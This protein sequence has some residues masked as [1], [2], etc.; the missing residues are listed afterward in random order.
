MEKVSS[1]TFFTVL[2]KGVCQALGWFFG[3]FGYKRDGKF[4]KCVWGLFATSAAVVMGIIAIIT[5]YEVSDGLWDMYKTQVKDKCCGSSYGFVSSYISGDIYYHDHRDGHGYI[6]NN[7]TGKKLIKDVAWISEPREKDTLVCFSDGK[8]RG[9]FGMK[10]GRVVVEPKYDHAWVFSEGL[11]GV[12]DGGIIKFIDAAGKVVI[13]NKMV[14]NPDM[15]GYVFHGG[16]CVIDSDDDEKHGLMDR[17]GKMALPLEYDII[18]PANDYELWRVQK[19]G[20]MAVFDKEMK[21]VVPFLECSSIYIDE[22]TIDVTM[23]DHTIRKYDMDGTLINDFYISCIRMLE[24]EK[25]DIVYKNNLA[26]NDDED[27]YDGDEDED[28][29]HPRATARLR[30]Y[31]AGD[32]YE[33]LITADG[34]IVTMPLYKDIDAIGY[35]LYLCESTNYDNVIVNGRGEIVK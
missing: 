9:Y 31:V 7:R 13:D 14:Y 16:Y 28:Y 12:D 26:G 29:Y 6:Y 35:D 5:I 3:L 18:S 10:S 1:K 32:G 21:F 27:E 15:D 11:A 17:T 34:H 33:G 23:D 24:Y 19:E 22:G 30:A 8:K 4:A 25:E 2:W 20:E